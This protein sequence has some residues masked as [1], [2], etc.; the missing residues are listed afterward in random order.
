MQRG[1][2]GEKDGAVG[3][4]GHDGAEA[5]ADIRQA[6][7]DDGHERARDHARA[8]DLAHDATRI[9]DAECLDVLGDDDAERERRQQV[10]RLVAGK[11]ALDGGGGVVGGDRR[12]RDTRR[13][14]H[15]RAHDHHQ[16]DEQRRPRDPSEQLGQGA[17]AHG[18]RV[19]GREERDREEQARRAH[20]D[21]LG[22]Q[23]HEH[24]EGGRAGARD[25]Q[26]RPDGEVDRRDEDGG[27][28]GVDA[29]GQLACGT[30]E[31][32]GD[33]A[34]HRQ[35][36]GRDKK[37]DHCRDAAG[38]RLQREQRRQDQVARAEEHREER[39]A[40]G[41]GLAGRERV[42]G[43]SVGHGEPFCRVADA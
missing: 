32:H 34:Q 3:G 9:G 42:L 37:A 33:D 35:A 39:D 30:H 21:A 27:E 41:K 4:V 23:R 20:G 25:R 18:Q 40:H 38:S 1:R 36:D 7:V 24:L 22:Q 8:R 29:R 11:K 5:R 31:R 15:R 6:A 14:D 17:G 43:W 12:L 19:G 28:H 26:A 2:G 16:K 10:H 13:G